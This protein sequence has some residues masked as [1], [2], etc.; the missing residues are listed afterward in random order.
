MSTLAALT[1][2]MATV[3]GD[4]L[5]W[6]LVL[7]GCVLGM[8]VGVLPGFGPPAATALLFPLVY[9]LAPLPGLS[10]LAGI[11]YGAK[12][13][14]A[15]TSIL[16]GIPGEADAV[17]TLLEGYPL[18]RAGRARQALTAA[19][20]ASFT[21]GM[22]SVM[23]L[24]ALAPLL[25]SAALYLGP[26]QRALLMAGALTLVVALGPGDSRKNLIMVFLGLALALVGLDPVHGVQR[27]T[28]GSWRL[29]GGIE[30]TS[31]LLGVFGLGDILDT[32]LAAPSAHQAKTRPLSHAGPRPGSA[33]GGDDGHG[34]DG[35]AAARPSWR[36]VFPA[37]RGTLIGFAAGLVPCG[38]G[39][40][41]SF[42]SYALE[43]RVAPDRERFGRGAWAGLVGP[44][45]SNNAAA[46]SSFAPL[47]L[48][49]LPTNPI[50]AAL[51]GALTVEG[52]APGPLLP[53]Q[54]PSFYWGLVASLLLGNIL[55]LL[56]GLGLVRVW[57]GLA[58]LPYR[59]LWPFI[60][61]LCLTGSWM[62]AGG[63]EGPIQCLL[64]GGMS[65]LLRRHGFAPAPLALA[66]VLG[67]RL[68]THLAQAL[69]SLA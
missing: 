65:A 22:V 56:L 19:T 57:A 26:G 55:L 64:F 32:L 37:L 38:A 68:E 47:L 69:M 9:V 27:L 17:A 1:Q 16:L 10:L 13:G 36:L 7:L 61:L 58:T 20:L 50:T 12:Y 43:K 54:Q 33:S 4:P 8:A 35:D 53:E 39:M 3:A 15:V 67:P 59:L 48:L 44:E 25:G 5:M 23:G 46:L 51:L 6:G 29:M 63:L 41:A 66:F 28:F 2:G 24:I 30:L 18:A 34:T 14:G 49:G 60:L 40:T 21:G 45:A 52:V 42:A 31:L 11:F 62:G